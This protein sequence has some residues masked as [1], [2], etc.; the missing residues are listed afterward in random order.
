MT[1]EWMPAERRDDALTF[2]PRSPKPLVRRGMLHLTERTAELAPVAA[3]FSLLWT[4][5]AE[6][7]RDYL[8]SL[9]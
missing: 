5:S 4:Y 3:P 1:G 2:D 6:M 9:A 8:G 7:N